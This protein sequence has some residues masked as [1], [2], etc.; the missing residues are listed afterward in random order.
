[1]HITTDEKFWTQY[2]DISILLEELNKDKDSNKPG[3]YAPTDILII[4]KPNKGNN[5]K[6]IQIVPGTKTKLY[7]INVVKYDEPSRKLIFNF[8][9][10]PKEYTIQM[11]DKVYRVK[12]RQP[13]QSSSSS[14]QGY[15]PQFQPQGYPPQQQFPQYP[16]Q[17][18]QQPQYPPQQ[19]Y[20]PPQQFQPQ[21]PPQFQ[22]QYPPQFSQYSQQQQGYPPQQQYPQQQPQQQFQPQ[23]QQ[24]PQ[25]QPQSNPYKFVKKYVDPNNPN[26]YRL[27]YCTNTGDK[28]RKIWTRTPCPPKPQLN[29]A[30]SGI[31]SKMN[32][33]LDI[34][35]AD[36]NK[37][38]GCDIWPKEP[39]ETIPL[40]EK[41]TL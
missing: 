11:D 16:Q 26:K 34:I 41:C 9:R 17:Q 19:P 21:Y 25:Q 36:I 2:E 8:G 1:M 22:P 12:R 13:I 27:E 35:A 14:P 6:E 29:P 20:Y 10:G 39:Q 40:N 15:P 24:Q 5:K 28:M 32:K 30:K 23:P 7:R 38:K 18:F 4:T 3:Y 33:G 37:P 31:F